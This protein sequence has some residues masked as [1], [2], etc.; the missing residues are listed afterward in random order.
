MIVQELY[1]DASKYVQKMQIAYKQLFG[2][3]P[4]KKNVLSP[5]MKGDHP[6]LNTSKFLDKEKPKHPITQC[7][8]WMPFLPRHPAWGSGIEYIADGRFSA[9]L[10]AALCTLDSLWVG[11]L[12]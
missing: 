1:I 12:L 11:H 8:I 9:I 6:E 2:T 5:L 4:P 7:H 3:D 10:M